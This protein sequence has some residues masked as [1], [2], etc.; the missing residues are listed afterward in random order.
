M[1][2]C[3]ERKFFLS[4]SN[5]I[6]FIQKT[7]HKIMPYYVDSIQIKISW[8]FNQEAICPSIHQQ[9]ETRTQ[10][11]KDI[12]FFLIFFSHHFIQLLIPPLNN[13]LCRGVIKL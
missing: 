7:F 6:G 13:I 1:I 9:V 4:I 5:L 12:C 8:F 11:L 3:D 2:D 10:F